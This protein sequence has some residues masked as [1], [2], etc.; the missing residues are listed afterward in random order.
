MQTWVVDRFRL[1]T[2]IGAAVGPAIVTAV[3]ALRA[4]R[5]LRRLGRAG[6]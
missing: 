1:A 5:E 3:R 2:A 6:N 4:R